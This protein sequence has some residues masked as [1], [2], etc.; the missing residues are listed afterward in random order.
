M[1]QLN[2]TS[3]ILNEPNKI[4][5]LPEFYYRR[6]NCD[7]NLNSNT[8]ANRYQIQKRIQKTVRVDSSLYT[9]NLAP[10][11]VYQ[12]PTKKTYNVCWN[13]MSD[14]VSPSY[15]PNI[16]PTGFYHS[17]NNRRHS[18]T[19]SRPGGQNPGGYGVDIKHNSYDRYLNRLKGKGPLRRGPVPNILAAPEIKFNRAYPIYGGKVMKTSIIAGCNCPVENRKVDDEVKIFD[20]P[21]FQPEEINSSDSLIGR[22]VFALYKTNQFKQGQILSFDNESALIEWNDGTT[23]RV[24]WANIKLFNRCVENVCQEKDTSRI[25]S[26]AAIDLLDVT[27]FYAD[28]TY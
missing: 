12:K 26:F 7:T 23:S 19:S 3:L 25:D 10:F 5:G 24:V 27:S 22:Q 14:R 9:S 1:N 18:V 8:P 15:Q 21:L 13:Q 4:I 28:N 16:V 2:K 20:N 11:S 17:I 6:R